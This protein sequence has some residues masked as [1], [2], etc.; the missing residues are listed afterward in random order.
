V[1]DTDDPQTDYRYFIP[2]EEVLPG[3]IRFWDNESYKFHDLLP[4]V[5]PEYFYEDLNTPFNVDW[6]LNEYWGDISYRWYH[7][8]DWGYKI[9]EDSYVGYEDR[10]TTA[11]W[12]SNWKATI[13]N[14]VDY[15]IGQG[16]PY[17]R[18]LVRSE[19][20]NNK[21]GYTLNSAASPGSNEAHK[22]MM[23][24]H[25]FIF[26]YDDIIF[27][28]ISQIGVPYYYGGKNP[29]AKMDCSGFVTAAKIQDMGID[30]NEYL[31]LGYINVQAYVNGWYLYPTLSDTVP[32]GTFHILPSEAF[33]GDLIAI[34]RVGSPMDWSL[35]H[36]GI[37]DWINADKE[38]NYIYHANL[39]HARGSIES[40]R[41]RVRFDNL[42]EVYRPF[43]GGYN[44]WFGNNRWFY[45][46]LRFTPEE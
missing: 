42:L 17:M 36:I 14:N 5:S 19:V 25:W 1:D 9:G 13:V 29:Y 18:L 4:N 7:V 43:L 34:R 26:I 45:K 46:F 38:S 32:T 23:S 31:R 30:A 10:D 27:W 37:I 6:W 24:R 16:H 3:V 15:K 8:R 35:A 28:A 22:I 33:R 20:S 2:N 41:R 39:I 21:Y 11:W 40:Y 12:G 44:F